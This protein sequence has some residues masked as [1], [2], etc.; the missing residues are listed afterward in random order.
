MLASFTPDDG[1]SPLSQVASVLCISLGHANAV[2][3]T[4]SRVVTLSTAAINLLTST[5]GGYLRSVIIQGRSFTRSPSR[6]VAR[7]T[8]ACT[9]SPAV[10]A[11]CRASHTSPVVARSTPACTFSPVVAVRILQLPHNRI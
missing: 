3:G 9:F 10:A 6:A 11:N 2:D 8:P 4:L 5:Y 1:A 7:S